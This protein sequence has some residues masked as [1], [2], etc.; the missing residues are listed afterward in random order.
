MLPESLKTLGDCPE[1]VVAV[2]RD[3]SRPQ[4]RARGRISP[5]AAFAPNSLP[6]R[7]P[8]A[9]RLRPQARRRPG[10]VTGARGQ[11]CSNM[12]DGNL[13][14]TPREMVIEFNPPLYRQRYQFVKDLV[15]EREPKK[16]ADLGCG[17]TSLMTLLRVCPCIELLVGVDINKDT[18]Q[19]RRHKL[20]PFIGH[21]LSPRDLDLTITLYHGSIVEKDSRL[22]GFDLITCIELIEHL[23]SGD[24]ASFPEV[25]FG[26]MSPSL[27]VISTPNAEFNPLFPSVTMRDS[28]HKFEWT[29]M[30]FQ[31]WAL[32]VAD[33]YN[34]SVAFTGVGDPPSGAESV[35]YCTQIGIF[36]QNGGKA[37]ELRVAELCEQHIYTTVFTVSYPSLQQE[38]YLV[39]QLM[40]QVSQH[41]E[42][43]RVGYLRSLQEQDGALKA[44]PEDPGGFGPSFTEDE[45]ARIEKSP[46]PFCVGSKFFVPLRRLLAYSRLSRLCAS[47]EVLRSRIAASMPLSGD[48]SAVVVGL[49]GR[50]DPQSRF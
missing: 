45:K 23:D 9:N 1:V 33:R 48:G 31:T 39:P 34:Y 5:L 13:E 29:R 12:V 49:H 21:Y 8:A 26:Y 25:V 7:P 43:L 47:E 3:P 27:V 44:K 35:G 15:D 38:R 41:V 16:V 4:A 14:D 36:Q 46:K 20:S 42:S 17:D 10:R 50:S 24:L 2:S 30:Q 22:L 37:P 32:C 11:E 6:S 28:D 40:S 19:R 18:L